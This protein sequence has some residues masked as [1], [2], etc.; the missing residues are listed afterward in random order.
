MRS[1]EQGCP[2]VNQFQLDSQPINYEVIET[3]DGIDNIEDIPIGAIK[4]NS[5]EDDEKMPEIPSPVKAI[6]S[7]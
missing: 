4:E 2:I 3:G 1:N 5:H 7:N 6:D